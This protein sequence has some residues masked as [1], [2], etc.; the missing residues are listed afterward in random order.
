ML[1]NLATQL[2]E[3]GRITTT[4][5]RARRVQP[6]AEKLITKAKRGDLHSRRLVMATVTDPTVVHVLFTDIAPAVANRAGGYTRITKVGNRKGDNAPMAL[7][8][9]V[10]EEVASKEKTKKAESSK[11]PVKAA[12]AA[13]VPE[14][15][16]EA[17]EDTDAE[18]AEDAAGEAT[19]ELADEAEQASAEAEAETDADAEEAAKEAMEEESIIEETEEK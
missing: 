2:F 15:V 17:V 11:R 12:A 18:Q 8:E 19:A 4:E 13:A 14:P 16:V 7:L 10:T 3:H 6:L 9:I 1:A 5:T